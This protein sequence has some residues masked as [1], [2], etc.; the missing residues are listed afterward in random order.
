MI[1]AE[2]TPGTCSV[3]QAL[4]TVTM[5]IGETAIA[6]CQECGS[7]AERVIH[8]KLWQ[9]KHSVPTHAEETARQVASFATYPYGL[10][11]DELVMCTVRWNIGPLNAD[12]RRV[13]TALLERLAA[14]GFARKVHRAGCEIWPKYRLCGC[15]WEVLS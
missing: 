3:C 15:P 13:A 6:L 12:E 4:S 8:N 9:L 14:L 2:I 10:L 5:T 11:L 7:E 1:R